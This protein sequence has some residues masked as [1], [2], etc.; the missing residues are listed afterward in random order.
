M[1][2]L[3]DERIIFIQDADGYLRRWT[4]NPPAMDP[5]VR[6]LIAAASLVEQQLTNGH[7]RAEAHND[8]V[9]ALAG[10]EVKPR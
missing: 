9:L 4:P 10:M 8:L 3:P 2:S 1:A 7:V 6:R 5:A